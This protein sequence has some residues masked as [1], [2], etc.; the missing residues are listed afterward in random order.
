V[1]AGG[2]ISDVDDGDW[3]SFRDV[4]FGPSG[5]VSTFTAWLASPKFGNQIEAWLDGPL[6][7]YL[8][9]ILT[10]RTSDDPTHPIEAAQSTP[11][12]TAAVSGRHTVY[13]HFDGP[14][15]ATASNGLGH[16]LGTFTHFLFR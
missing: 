4:D 2:A 8:G 15:N 10:Q 14:E 13:I 5:S 3:V 9:T 6:G 11:I 1:V 7:T 12:N 16:D